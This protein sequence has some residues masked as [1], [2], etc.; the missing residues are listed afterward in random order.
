M[1]PKTIDRR[2][3]LIAGLGVAG[4]LIVPGA[5]ALAAPGRDLSFV[6]LHTGEKLGTTYWLG[7]RHVPSACHRIDALLRDY[8]TGEIAPISTHLLDLL[9]A[10]RTRLGTEAPFQVISGERSPKTNA[11]LA[12]AGRG[13]A[14]KSLHMRGMAIDIRVPDC[15]LKRLRAVAVDLKGGG[16]GYYPKSGF[17]HVDV[18]RVRYW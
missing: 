5:S 12:S 14:R 18:G 17:I 7:G 8:R 6:N 11:R 9:H 3:F 16:V 10:I 2:K 4:A 1:F 15:S 13:V